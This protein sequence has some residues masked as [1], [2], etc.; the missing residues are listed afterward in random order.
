M[1]TFLSSRAILAN[2]HENVARTKSSS[3]RRHRKRP[4][5]HDKH[6]SLHSEKESKDHMKEPS[7]PKPAGQDTLAISPLCLQVLF[8]AISSS[9]RTGKTVTD[10]DGEVVIPK[11]PMRRD[12]DFFM[13]VMFPMCALPQVRA[14]CLW[15]HS[16]G[17][18]RKKCQMRAE[19]CS[20]R[21]WGRFAYVSFA[22]CRGCPAG[23]NCGLCQLFALLI[24]AEHYRAAGDQCLPGMESVTSRPCSW[25][26]QKRDVEPQPV[27][28][29][30]I[31]KA[32]SADEWRRK[33]ISC[34]LYE[35]PCL[36][37][38]KITQAE[39]DDLAAKLPPQSR[40]KYLLPRKIIQKDT[41]FGKTP[42]GSPGSYQLKR[43]QAPAGTVD[44]KSK[45][46]SHSAYCGCIVDSVF[47]CIAIGSA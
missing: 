14:G 36:D 44:K 30:V 15:W 43:F 18:R 27:M 29:T 31:E 24:A 16:A 34:T 28:T 20:R 19:T 25:G 7:F 40:M 39:I 3:Q 26:P 1:L 37:L 32:K 17:R 8:W 38:R 10:T 2:E 35:A 4:H 5:G 13:G 45:V 11:K 33:P 6:N 47:S 23:A 21:S 41:A 42:K 12:Y 9:V 46:P 22:T